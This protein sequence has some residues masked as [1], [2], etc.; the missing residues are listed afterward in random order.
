MPRKLFVDLARRGLGQRQDDLGVGEGDSAG[1]H[2]LQI[3]VSQPLLPELSCRGQV[4]GIGS[5]TPVQENALV[6]V[7]G[8]PVALQLFVLVGHPLVQAFQKAVGNLISRREIGNPAVVD[9]EGVEVCP[10]VRKFRDIRLEKIQMLRIQGVQIT[11]IEFFRHGPIQ[12]FSGVVIFLQQPGGDVGDAAVVGA[13]GQCGWR[14]GLVGGDQSR[15]V[16]LQEDTHT[17]P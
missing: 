6:G 1:D 12:R 5:I 11:V 8:E 4:F 3:I 2:F 13:G 17:R 9:G 16:E 14:I 7:Q 15:G 10:V